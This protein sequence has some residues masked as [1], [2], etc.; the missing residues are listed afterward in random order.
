MKNI[1][2]ALIKFQSLC[3]AIKKD[4]TNPFHKSKY[5]SLDTILDTIKDPLNSCDLAISQQCVD[6]S[7]EVITLKTVLYHA[8]GEFMDSTLS[9]KPSQLTG[10]AYGSIL[11]YMRRYSIS[12]I[13]NLATMDDDD[14]NAETVKPTE[15]K[16][17][18]VP[19]PYND[20]KR[21]VRKIPEGAELFDADDELPDFNIK[22]QGFGGF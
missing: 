15:A 10:Q 11:T 3:P 21:P 12:S 7:G 1:I 8:S 5:A 14:C 4:S 6:N 16:K 13:L 9:M 17:P 2:L 18:F 20:N 22:P 19:K